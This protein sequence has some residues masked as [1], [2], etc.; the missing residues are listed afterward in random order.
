VLSPRWRKVLRDLWDNK[1]RSTLVILSIAIGVIAFGGLFTSRF[2][3][4][5]NLDEQFLAANPDDLTFSLSAFDDELVRWMKR[6]EGVVDVQPFTQYVADV[7]GGDLTYTSFIWAFSDFDDIQVNQFVPE[8]GIYPPPRGSFLIERSYLEKLNLEVGDYATFEFDDESFRLQFAGTVH[9]I[10]VQS[11]TVGEIFYIYLNQRTL[12]ELNR[13]T[14]YNQMFVTVDRSLFDITGARLSDKAD[15]LRDDLEQ[16][17]LEVRSVTI[18]QTIEHWASSNLDGIV[19]ILITVGLFALILTGFLV[20]NTIAGV[21]SQ[22]RKTVGIMKI[23][24]ASQAQ[25]IGVYLVMAGAFGAIAL[26]IAI[27]GSNLLARAISS[28]LGPGFTNF[29]IDVFRVPFFILLIQVAVALLAPILSALGPVLTGVNVSAAAAISDHNASGKTNPI[30]AA[31]SRLGGLPRPILLAIRNTFRRKVRLVMTLIT[32]VMA[33]ALFIAIINVRAAVRIDAYDIFRMQR[34][35]VVV[36]FENPYSREGV[37]RR[38]ETLDGVTLAEGWWIEQANIERPDGSLTESYALNG[39][40]A[41][42]NFIDPDMSAGRWLQPLTPS[43]RDDIIVSDEIL[44][45][46]PWIEVG[47]T[48][49]LDY[50]GDARTWNVVGIVNTDDFGGEALPFY[51]HYESATRFTDGTGLMQTLQVRTTDSSR[52]FQESMEVQLERLFERADFEVSSTNNSASF[53]ENILAAFDVIITLLIL[54]AILVA[55]VG[56]LGLAG[57]M[58]LSVLERTREIGVMRSVGASTNMLRLMFIV[59]GVIIGLLSWIV[60]FVLSFPITSLFGAALGNVIR[61]KP[62]TYILTVSG[63]LMWLGIVI[64]V[65]IVASL[66]PAQR[67]T[68]ISIREAI[69]YE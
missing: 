37:I 48:I 2:V 17:G 14:D 30:D 43:N 64:A 24:G 10:T 33:G 13:S 11:G 63:P 35:D 69:S 20:V 1:S 60:A 61:G 19:L 21:L 49:T 56:G 53:L 25:I 40:P 32:L 58:S 39:V 57:T 65:S 9:D 18:E 46:E 66:L 54:V 34:F 47:N 50:Q 22:Q 23:I 67:A 3:L 55:A 28:F 44:A 6:Q 26:L 42:S 45:V 38:T 4:L 31:L 59:E 15:D 5:G 29:D 12:R 27:P 41:E 16:R 7:T 8:A 62:W 36:N 51:T 68:Q 52:S